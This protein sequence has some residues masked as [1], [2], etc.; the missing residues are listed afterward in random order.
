MVVRTALHIALTLLLFTG[1]AI[2]QTTHKVTLTWADTLNPPGTTYN[3]KRSPGLCSGTP[4]FAT[5][6][7]AIAVKT[8]E[9][10][11]VTPGPYCYVVT[12]TSGGVESAP[13]NTALANVPSF[14][15]S[16][17]SVVVQ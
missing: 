15:P 9:D 6:A 8:Y 7:T 4:V 17:L 16:A 10:A 13:S 12:A 14:P 2:G 1:L 5:M 11:A 3:I